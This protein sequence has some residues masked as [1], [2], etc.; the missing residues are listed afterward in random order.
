MYTLDLYN[1]DIIPNVKISSCALILVQCSQEVGGWKE[2]C[3][4]MVGWKE[5]GI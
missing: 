4:D 2:R 1:F 3:R 5:G